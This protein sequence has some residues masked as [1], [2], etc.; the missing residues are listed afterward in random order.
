M[1]AN[2]VVLVAAVG[3]TRRVGVVLEQVDVPGDAFFS[4]SGV[5]VEQQPLQDALACL[6]VGYQIDQA[7]ALWCCVLGVAADVQ[8]EPRAVT[9]EDVAAAAPGHD[10][11]EQVPGHL[12]RRE[13]PLAAK[14]AGDAVLVFQPENAPV[15]PS[16]SYQS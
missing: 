11:A 5:R 7:V 10:P 14:S 13:P 15:H 2:E 12:V 16:A 4:Q 3:V 9:Q 6:V 8:I 1:P